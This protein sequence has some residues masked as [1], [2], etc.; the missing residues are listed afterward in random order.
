MNSMYFE[1]FDVGQKFTTSTRTVTDEDIADFH[2]LTGVQNR[3]FMDDKFAENSIHKGRITPG[4]LTLSL[5]TGL[6]TSLGIIEDTAMA[7]L[8][9]ERMRLPVPV[10]PGDTIRVEVE[11]T[12]KIETKKPDR[13]VVKEMFSVMNQRDENVM[14]YEMAHLIMRRE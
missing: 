11:I 12:E 14:S 3:L 6:F 10:K 5:A 9:L 13:G 7:F 2:K 4:P 8:G 1:D